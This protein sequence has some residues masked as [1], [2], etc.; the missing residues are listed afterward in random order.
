MMA[1]SLAGKYRQKSIIERI[2]A[3]FLDNVRKVVTREQI[4]EVARDPATGRVPENWHQRLSELRTDFGYTIHSSRDSKELKRSEY[5]L[6]SAE[7]RTIAGTRVKINP[8]AWKAVLERA[9]NACEWEDSGRRCGL[10]AGDIDPVGGGMVK[11]TADHKTPHSYNPDTDAEDPQQWQALC[12][13]HQ[14]VKKNF[15][16]HGT[17]KMNI[18]AIVQA[19]T[20][21]EKKAVYEML[22]Q[23]FGE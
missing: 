17:G 2:E 16:D 3:L 20:N 15:W 7:K 8:Q 6:V 18:Y 9:G 1:K 10:R 13:R 22:K 23:Y 21:K 14:V 12:G 5:R 4:L 11:L 19:A